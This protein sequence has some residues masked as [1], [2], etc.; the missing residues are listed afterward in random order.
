MGSLRDVHPALKGIKDEDI[1]IDARLLGA[2]SAVQIAGTL[3]VDIKALVEEVIVRTMPT[4]AGES[5]NCA[6]F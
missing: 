6:K 5:S 3:W 4:E 2:S 1:A